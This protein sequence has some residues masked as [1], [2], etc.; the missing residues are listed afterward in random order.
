MTGFKIGAYSVGL[1]DTT[2][3]RN[4]LTTTFD[5]ISANGAAYSAGNPNTSPTSGVLA[6]FDSTTRF[7]WMDPADVA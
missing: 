5:R 4:H 3:T 6:V 7:I 2:V 1:I